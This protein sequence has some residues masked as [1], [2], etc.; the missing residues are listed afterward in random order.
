MPVLCLAQA[1]GVQRVEA[2]VLV[3]SIDRLTPALQT[4]AGPRA[5]PAFLSSFANRARMFTQH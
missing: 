5:R 3:V 4:A 2:D 1:Q